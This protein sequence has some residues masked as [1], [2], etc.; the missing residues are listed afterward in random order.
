[1]LIRLIDVIRNIFSIFENKK[2]VFDIELKKNIVIKEI[3]SGT[4]INAISVL[5]PKNIGA[6]KV[7]KINR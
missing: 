1:M 3:E 2:F 6:K 7:R 5:Y 4:K